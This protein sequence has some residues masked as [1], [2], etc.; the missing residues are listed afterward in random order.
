M[1]ALF[2]SVAS[3]PSCSISTQQDQRA[4][5][6][7]VQMHGE[8]LF[9]KIEYVSVYLF[10]KGL[11]CLSPFKSCHTAWGQKWT[12]FLFLSKDRIGLHKLGSKIF[13]SSFCELT[14]SLVSTSQVRGMLSSSIESTSI[15][16][17]PGNSTLSNSEA[18]NLLF[19]LQVINV[20]TLIKSQISKCCSEKEAN[21]FFPDFGLFRNC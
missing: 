14:L 16:K 10:V 4:T 13:R 6:R 11:F 7:I 18:R 1:L 12:S 3:T 8:K 5:Q 15:V 21:G 17:L 19:V 2:N 20:R 9:P